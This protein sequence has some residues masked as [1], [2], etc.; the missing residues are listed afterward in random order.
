MPVTRLTNGTSSSRNWRLPKGIGEGVSIYQFIFT[1]RPHYLPISICLTR[2][3][4]GLFK[5]LVRSFCRQQHLGRIQLPSLHQF[6]D[7]YGHLCAILN[8]QNPPCQQPI[9]D[10]FPAQSNLYA[11]PS[12]WLKLHIPLGIPLNADN[13]TLFLRSRPFERLLE[14]RPCEVYRK[15][16]LLIRFSC[17]SRAV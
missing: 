15:Y 4:C 14:S 8:S 6:P 5:E 11:P 2:N 1:S 7:F 3:S 12:Q 9:F 10:R 13:G 17:P 16:S